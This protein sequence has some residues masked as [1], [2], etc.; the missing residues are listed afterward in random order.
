MN[1]LCYSLLLT[2]LVTFLRIE[3]QAQAVQIM[4]PAG[5]EVWPGG[6]TQIIRW[7]YSNLTM[8]G[9]NIPL[10]INRHGYQLLV[11]I[12]RRLFFGHKQ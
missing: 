3:V 2:W 8:C 4:A 5:G 12:R 1:K 7:A 6:S 10:M 11:L 9:L